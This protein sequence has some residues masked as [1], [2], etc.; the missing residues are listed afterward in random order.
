MATPSAIELRRAPVTVAILAK[1][2]IAGLA[3]TRLIPQ[4][5]AAGAARLAGW[6]LERSVAT[7]LAA[8]LGPVT[9][10]CAPDCAH[11]AFA[12]CA[13]DAHVALQPQPAGDLGVRMLAAA[14]AA[15]TPAGVLI[16]GSDCPQLDANTLR[17]A[18]GALATH[19]ASVIPAED[20][21]YVLLGLRRA[22]PAV[23]SDLPWSTPAVMAH[24]RARLAALGWRV[25]EAAP[26]WDVDEPADYLRLAALYPEVNRIIADGGERA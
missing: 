1:A 5:G 19:D 13:S 25:A 20:G 6:M 11:P 12:A 15:T 24:T 14:C 23:F 18:A 2:P 26:C 4:L 16:I 17:S 8:R 22:D 9:L 10:W 3:K 21:G 7:A